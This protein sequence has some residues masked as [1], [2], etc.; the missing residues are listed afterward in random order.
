MNAI[1]TAPFTKSMKRQT[2]FRHLFCVG[3]VVYTESLVS[4]ANPAFFVNVFALVS[5]L[6]VKWSLSESKMNLG[7]G[8]DGRLKKRTVQD[9]RK[10]KI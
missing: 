8:E 2:Q 3:G 6:V 5:V 7:T 1:L 4:W 10:N 9:V